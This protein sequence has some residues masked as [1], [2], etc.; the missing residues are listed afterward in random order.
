MLLVFAI[1]IHN[2]RVKFDRFGIFKALA[3]QKPIA[4]ERTVFKNIASAR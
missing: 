4:T 2:R 3:I 1:Y